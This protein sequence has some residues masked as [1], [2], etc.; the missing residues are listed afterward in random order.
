[1]ADKLPRYGIFEIQILMSKFALAKIGPEAKA[2]QL[3]KVLKE[4]IKNI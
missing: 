1:M 2:F 4:M 3:Q